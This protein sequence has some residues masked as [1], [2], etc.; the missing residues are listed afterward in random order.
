MVPTPQP[1]NNDQNNTIAPPPALSS[2][3]AQPSETSKTK[4]IIIGLLVVAT[5]ISGGVGA[6]FLTKNNSKKVGT[7]G[8]TPIVE[9]RIPIIPQPSDTNIIN[10]N[11]APSKIASKCITTTLQSDWNDGYVINPKLGSVSF[12][13]TELLFFKADSSE[14]EYKI[15]AKDTARYRRIADTLKNY[16]EDYKFVIVSKINNSTPSN[17][18]TDK[19]LAEARYQKAKKDFVDLGFDATKFSQGPPVLYIAGYDSSAARNVSIF[20]LPKCV[21]VDG[22]DVPVI[23][24][25]DY[26]S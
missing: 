1:N 7:D 14:Y 12:L 15:D 11:K 20:F 3:I 2:D 26:W 4:L 22:V 17:S 8:K 23:D 24:N 19:A 10:A 18:A 9:S 21:S 5:L 6:Y 13:N 25:S 16:K